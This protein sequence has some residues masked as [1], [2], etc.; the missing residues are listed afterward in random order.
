LTVVRHGESTAN[1]AF[2]AADARSSLDSGVTG[3]DADI[4]LTERGTDEARAVGRYLAALP[5]DRHPEIVLCSPYLRARQTWA[6]ARATARADGVELPHPRLDGRLCDRVQ[7]ELEMLTRAAIAARFPDEPA[8][9]REHGEFHY[10]PPGGESLV[11]V[12]DRLS[13]VLADLDRRPPGARVL[14]VAHDA[15]VLMLRHLIEGLSLDHLDE[16]A[17]AGPVANASLT[18]WVGTG[19]GLALAEYN[20]VSHLGPAPS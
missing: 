8:R 20:A 12:A 4:P 11:D 6:L 18:R 2:P 9:R 19:G 15:V 17:R 7:G 10:R 5:P 16:V 3:R 14:L 13:G 1:V